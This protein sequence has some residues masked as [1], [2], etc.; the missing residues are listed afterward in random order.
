MSK[1][2]QEVYPLKKANSIMNERVVIGILTLVI[3]ALLV[4][5]AI[6]IRRVSIIGQELSATQDVIYEILLMQD[7]SDIVINN[8]QEHVESQEELKPETPTCPIHNRVISRIFD[9]APERLRLVFDEDVKIGAPEDFVMLLDNRILISGQWFCAVTEVTYTIEAIFMFWLRDDE[10]SLELLSYSPFG[11]A[12]WQD[13]WESPNQHSWVRYHALETVPVRFYAM[14]G[15]WDEVWYNIEYLN[16]Q[17]FAEELAYHA[18]QHL[19]RRIVD[20]WFVGRILYVNLHHSE[21][22]NGVKVQEY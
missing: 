8:I 20:A 21:S 15:D 3:I 18:L 6:A 19:N 12:G 10:I 4:Y 17:T 9:V 7:A 5:S 14:G 11:W 2:I 1:D 16:G 13:P 22:N